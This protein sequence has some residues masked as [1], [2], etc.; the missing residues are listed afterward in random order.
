LVD[1]CQGVSP[2]LAQSVSDLDWQVFAGLEPHAVLSGS[3]AARSRT[4]SDASCSAA[5]MW[6]L[7]SEGSFFRDPLG[8]FARCQIVETHRDHDAGALDAHLTM[9]DIGINAEMVLPVHDRAS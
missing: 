8:G 4:I 5:R 9:V 6:A 7:R 3:R 1:N 2:A